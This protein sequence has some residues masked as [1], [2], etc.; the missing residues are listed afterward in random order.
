MLLLHETDTLKDFA[1]S[2]LRGEVAVENEEK[3][4]DMEELEKYQIDERKDWEKKY[5]VYDD[6][7]CL[8]VDNNVFFQLPSL[9]VLQ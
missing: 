5:D 3:L 6:F 8:H 2:S 9:P 4:D 7:E 1:T